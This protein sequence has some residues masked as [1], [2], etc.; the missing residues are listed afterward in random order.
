MKRTSCASGTGMQGEDAQR[1]LQA[2]NDYRRQ[3]GAANMMEMVSYYRVHSNRSTRPN[4]STGALFSG[5]NRDNN[6]NLNQI[7]RCSESK[8]ARNYTKLGLL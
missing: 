8:N 3:E 4:R 1:I 7:L 2:Q 5:E 6:G